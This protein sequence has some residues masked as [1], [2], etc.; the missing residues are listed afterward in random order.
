MRSLTVALA[1][2]PLLVAAPALAHEGHPER[3]EFFRVGPEDFGRHFDLSMF[4]GSRLG[5][6]VSSMTEELR[7]AMGAPK[8][9]GL[10]VNRV[11]EGTPA[12]KAGI[13]AGDV[14]VEVAGEEIAEV[15][16]V[17][18]A[19]AEKDG[20]VKVEVIRDKRRV[21]L[22]ADIEKQERIRSVLIGGEAREEIE[23]LRE[24][25]EEL[26]KRLE[27]LEKR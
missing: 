16:D 24:R 14:L 3:P 23:A 11:L 9:A 2:L 19:L 7:D 5:V 6:Q 26:E 18:K 15:R 17:W 10:L 8:S 13:K 22:K 12:E 25:V 21:N 27:K 4:R 1:A 20:E